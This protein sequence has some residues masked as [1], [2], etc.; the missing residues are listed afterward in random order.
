MSLY[1]ALFGVNSLAPFL[2]TIL[3]LDQPNG[4]WNTGRFRDAYLNPEGTEVIVYTRNGGGN[5]ECW[6]MQDGD[7][8][9][10]DCRCA[11]CCVNFHLPQHP[12]YCTDYDDDFDCTYAYIHFSIPDEFKEICQGLATGEAP[13][14]IS[15]RFTTLIGALEKGEKNEQTEKALAVGKEIMGK[16]DEVMKKGE[17][18]VEV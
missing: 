7:E 4:N 16:L 8:A 5:R 17:G 11:G 15:Q 13:I 2:L 9:G 1:N 6:S 14:S 12:N 3:D 18:G 10:D